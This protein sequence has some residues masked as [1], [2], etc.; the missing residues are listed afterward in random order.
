[1]DTDL[2]LAPLSAPSPCGEDLSF[3]AEFDQIA[4]MRRADDPTLDQG[5]WVTSVKQSDWPGVARLCQELLATR[6]KDLRLAQWLTEARALSEGYVGLNQGLALCAALCEQH[7]DGLHP[8]PEGG[9]AEERIGN[10]AWLL[11]RLVD[12]STRL[13]VTSSRKGERFSLR[14][15]NLARLAQSQAERSGRPV[16]EAPAGSTGSAGSGQA[17]TVARFRQA[18]SDTP[19]DTL[20]QTLDAARGARAQLLAWQGV[21][22]ARLGQDGPSFVSAREALEQ[23]VHELERLARESGVTSLTGVMGST[24]DSPTHNGAATVFTPQPHEGA[25][26]LAAPVGHR[27]GGGGGGGGNC[28][29]PLTRA[30]ALR[31]LQQVADFFRRTEP[32]SP[33]AYL[34]DKAI[35][36]GEMPLHQWLAEVVKDPSSMSHLQELLGLRSADDTQG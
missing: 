14:D 3:S 9:D 33:V 18:L 19:A 23:A 34:A 21:V 22:D 31:Q 16:G 17:V 6:T 32:H 30:E 1:M 36:W 4:E 2:L 28:Q 15:L 26:A 11:Q 29:V 20:R 24:F 27:E 12:L 13:P 25:N 5:E 8:R 35:K 10:I 7:W